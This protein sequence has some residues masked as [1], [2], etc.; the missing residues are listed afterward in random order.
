MMVIL[1]CL[2]GRA[3]I[4]GKREKAPLNGDPDEVEMAPSCRSLRNIKLL[5]WFVA[6]SEQNR[7]IAKSEIAR[8]IERRLR[9]VHALQLRNLVLSSRNNN[10]ARS[11]S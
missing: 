11:I 9:R 10:Y 4:L 6:G 3:D 8:P 5:N 2:A 7:V 1:F